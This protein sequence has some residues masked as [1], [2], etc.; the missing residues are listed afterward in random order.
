MIPSV[1]RGEMILSAVRGGMI[2]PVVRG[3]KDPIGRPR[4]E[5]M[6]PVGSSVQR[7][8]TFP[9]VD[10][11]PDLTLD[12]QETPAAANKS[13]DVSLLGDGW[14]RG[15]FHCL[16]FRQRYRNC[17]PASIRHRGDAYANSDG[18]GKL[19]ESQGKSVIS[20]R[21]RSESC[22]SQLNR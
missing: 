6:S 10:T 9:R 4:R 15:I 13:L 2:L 11:L 19:G 14:R 3:R 18:K 7:G 16:H 12:R 5:G 20:P 8:G 22:E 17:Q 1:V 21:N